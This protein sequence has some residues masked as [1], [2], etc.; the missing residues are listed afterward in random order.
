M[1]DNYQACPGCPLISRYFWMSVKYVPINS[2]QY[3]IQLI[4]VRY[5]PPLRACISKNYCCFKEL[6]W[7][8][9]IHY[10]FRELSIAD[11]IN[12][13]NI[14]VKRPHNFVKQRL[15]SSYFCETTEILSIKNYVCGQNLKLNYVATYSSKLLSTYKMHIGIHRSICTY[16]W[17]NM[18]KVWISD[19][20]TCLTAHP[21]EFSLTHQRQI[22]W[23]SKIY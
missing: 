22:K 17:W 3:Y 16:L 21:K 11:Q 5:K 19:C 9:W 13:H 1:P 15:S 23:F 20:S 12:L 2:C 14:S 10:C 7:I 8:Q 4:C 6:F 18:R